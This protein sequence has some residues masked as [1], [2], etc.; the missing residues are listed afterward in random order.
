MRKSFSFAN[1]KTSTI[2][3]MWFWTTVFSFLIW[4][5]IAVQFDLPSPKSEWL[6][7]T[8]LVGVLVCETHKWW[9]RK[10]R[11]VGAK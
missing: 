4:T 5:A 1:V 8:L 3:S 2:A 11:K 7:G 9:L 6:L 10:N